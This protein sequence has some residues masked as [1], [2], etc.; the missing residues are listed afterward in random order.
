MK[1]YKYLTHSLS[2]LN[3]HTILGTVPEGE[4]RFAGC[5]KPTNHRD[6]VMELCSFYRKERET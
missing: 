4:Y 6:N 5:P 3:A 1:D 2:C